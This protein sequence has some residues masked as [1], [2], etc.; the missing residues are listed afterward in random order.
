MPRVS[1]RLG[2]PGSFEGEPGRGAE[3]GV[4]PKYLIAGSYTHQGLQG[5]MKEGG[6]GRRAALE[7]AIQGVGGK[8][9]ACYFAFGDDDVYLICDAPDNASVASVA[10]A[11]GAAGGATTKTIVLLTPEEVDQATRKSVDYRPPG[12]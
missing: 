3:G 1:W 7:K 8:L 2:E 4:M 6:T 12:G 5:L 10:L 9:E 11:A